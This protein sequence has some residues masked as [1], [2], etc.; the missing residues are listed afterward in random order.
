[1]QTPDIPLTL[2]NC[3]MLGFE[4][5]LNQMHYYIA[6]E[7]VVRRARNSAMAALPFAIFA[8]LTHITSRAPDFFKIPNE[9]L[10][11]VGFDIE[12]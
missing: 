9:G 12:I 1:M 7:T 6:H 2:K 11:E 3:K 4:V 5:D 10:S 8:F